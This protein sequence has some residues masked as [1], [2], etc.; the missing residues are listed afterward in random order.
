MLSI[1][2]FPSVAENLIN[3][4]LDNNY[5]SDPLL[6]LNLN[7]TKPTSSL[8]LNHTTTYEINNII[9]SL[10]PRDSYGYDGISSIILKIS[11]PFI[12]SPLL[13][14]L[15]KPFVLEYSPKE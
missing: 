6:Y 5:P 8:S 12:L 13:T 1:L 3:K 10:K 4:P 15:I 14:Y 7:F 9:Q 2:F 11:V